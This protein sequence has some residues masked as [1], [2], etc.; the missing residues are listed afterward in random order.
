MLR[1]IRIVATVTPQPIERVI[2]NRQHGVL[3][4][5][6]QLQAGERALVRLDNGALAIVPSEKVHPE[7]DV[8]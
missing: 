6:L 8:L 4:T 2:V 7:K 5:M 3:L 1:K